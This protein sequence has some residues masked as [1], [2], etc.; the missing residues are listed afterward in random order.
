METG[1]TRSHPLMPLGILAFVIPIVITLIYFN[2]AADSFK[3]LGLTNATAS[4]LL[5]GSVIGSMFNIPLARKQIVL[6]DPRLADLPLALRRILVVW[7]YYPP[8]VEDEVVAINVGG[9]LIPIGFS[10]YLL[11][12]P[13]TAILTAAL[14]TGIVAVTAKLMARPV[15]GL[16]IT[17]PGF[18]PPLLAAGVSI[19]LI[20]LLGYPGPAAPV[21]YI[22]G[23]LGTLIGADLLNLPLVLRGGLLAANPARLWTSR[24]RDAIP[25]VPARI[26]SIGGAGVFDGVFLT[27][28]I[29]PLLVALHL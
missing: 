17:L 21:A 8:A 29:A 5:V 14:A 1:P 2:L 19:G 22:C 18:V 3:L 7:H 12:L 4:L 23:S 6:T 25:A 16:G 9:A 27:G 20:R 26:L 24:K 10:I 28:V 13:T 15:P 11:T